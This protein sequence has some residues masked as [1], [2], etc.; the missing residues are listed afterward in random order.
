MK[1]RTGFVT[2]S[3]SCSYTC[4]K[5]ESKELAEYVKGFLLNNSE[6]ALV[7]I[8]VDGDTVMGADQEFAGSI[9]EVFDVA[10]D[11]GYDDDDDVVE[12][13]SYS[14]NVQDNSEERAQ[15][16]KSIID[17]FRE[18]LSDDADSTYFPAYYSA[19]DMDTIKEIMNKPETKIV[20]FES[21]YASL[22]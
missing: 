8:T 10:Y 5:V 1:I 9:D 12:Y 2:N 11:S 16:V 7:A 14:D 13:C 19:W 21:A 15:I 18:A 17:N 4:W 3:S 22:D 20:S 6:S